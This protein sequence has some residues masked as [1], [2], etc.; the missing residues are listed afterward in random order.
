DATCISLSRFLGLYVVEL[1]GSQISAAGKNSSSLQ[2]VTLDESGWS[3]DSISGNFPSRMSLRL[4]RQEVFLKKEV[5]EWR[6]SDTGGVPEELE[7]GD[8]GGVRPKPTTV[9]KRLGNDTRRG[10]GETFESDGE[11]CGVEG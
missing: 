3:S 1:L 6:R 9:E 8:C 4:R 7:T 2:L 5:M 11:L 10:G